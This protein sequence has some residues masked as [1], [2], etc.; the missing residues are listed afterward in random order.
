MLTSTVSR[1][2]RAPRH[3]QSARRDPVITATE[4]ERYEAT[5]D[6]RMLRSFW[7]ERPNY[8][9]ERNVSSFEDSGGFGFVSIRLQSVGKNRR[10]GG[11][12]VTQHSKIE[13]LKKFAVVDTL[14]HQLAARLRPEHSYSQAL[15]VCAGIS[16]C[17]LFS[18][19]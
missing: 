10:G 19:K 13:V 7:T 12:P 5:E 3:Y 16:W 6:S 4:I 11:N 2:V 14:R 18:S 9:Y 8:E 15:V 1:V 17:L